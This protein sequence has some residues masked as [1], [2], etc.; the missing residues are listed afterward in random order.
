MNF[1]SDPVAY[2]IPFFVLDDVIVAIYYSPFKFCS[3]DLYAAVLESDGGTSDLN[4]G[5]RMY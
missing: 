3:I 2:A 4:L 5:V 1:L